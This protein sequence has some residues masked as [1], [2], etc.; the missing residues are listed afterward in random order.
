[1]PAELS[2]L[3]KQIVECRACPRLV[4]YREDVARQKRRA[5]RH[6]NYW[7]KPVPSWG[8]LNARLLILGLAPAAHGANRTGRMF[9]GDRSGEFLYAAL[10]RY[11][12]CNQPESRHSEDGLQLKD[13]YITAAI[14]CAPPAN[15]PSRQELSCCRHF[16]R[17]ELQL[18]RQVRVIVTLG[19]IAWETFLATRKE[20]GLPVPGRKPK[21]EHAGVCRLDPQ[22]LCVAS[23]HPSQQNTQTGR[24][25]RPMF[26]QVFALARRELP[27]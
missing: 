5:Y 15:K 6:W 3:Q 27:L 18:L 13:T 8:D 24:L 11:G 25:T 14:H 1:M 20:L 23:Y 7:G 12:F 2:E 10:Y 19:R 9:T 21:F 17:S 26:E 16:L 4:E 22:T